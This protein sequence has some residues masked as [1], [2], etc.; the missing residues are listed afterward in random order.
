VA[1]KNGNDDCSDVAGKG[2]YVLL[3]IADDNSESAN[4]LAELLR[5]LL[6]PPLEIVLAYDGQEAVEA[7]TAGGAPPDAVLL[8]IEMPPMNGID[9]AIAI[10]RS[11]PKATTALIAMTGHSG[12][13]ILASARN[14]FDHVLL[15]PLDVQELLPLLP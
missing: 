13:S 15:K 12:R 10:R 3:L 7:A 9:A 1:L 11:L 5:L 14:A 2:I 4:D 6:P 8:D